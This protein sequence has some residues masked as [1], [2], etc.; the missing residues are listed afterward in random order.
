MPK[1]RSKSG[2]KRRIFVWN[3]NCTFS[4]QIVQTIP[5]CNQLGVT[6]QR[7]EFK[8]FSH[9]ASQRCIGIQRIFSPQSMTFQ[10][11]VLTVKWNYYCISYSLSQGKDKII[12]GWIICVEFWDAFIYL[13]MFTLGCLTVTM[14][15]FLNLSVRLIRN[16][17][18]NNIDWTINYSLLY[19]GALQMC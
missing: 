19:P 7:P 13:P 15:A 11:I 2:G 6:F 18:T 17:N 10:K 8:S 12:I 5:D 16:R 4:F 14:I 1:S 9:H 3:I